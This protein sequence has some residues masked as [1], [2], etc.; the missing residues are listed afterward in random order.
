MSLRMAEQPANMRS[1]IDVAS[2]RALVVPS[3]AA[4]LIHD[5]MLSEGD[6]PSVKDVK[7]VTLKHPALLKDMPPSPKLVEEIPMA[8]VLARPKQIPSG[9]IIRLGQS[10]LRK[11]A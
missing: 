4:R 10:N 2:I 7:R 11:A 5:A 6:L 8:E 9:K 1:A 3:T